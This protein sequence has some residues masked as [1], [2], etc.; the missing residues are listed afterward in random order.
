[1]AK[2]TTIRTDMPMATPISTADDRLTLAQ[3]LSPAFPIGGFAYSQGLEEPMATGHVRTAADVEAWLRDCLRFGTPKMDAIIVA[4]ARR[5]ADAGMLSD[6]ILAYASCAERE[7]ELMEQGRAFSAL[8]AAMSDETVSI[9]PFPVAVGLATRALSL[10]DTEVI[11][12]FLH[13]VAAQMISAATRFLPLGQSE[14][15]AMLARLAPLLTSL[16]T[17]AAAAQLDDIATFTPGADM[18]AMRH[19]TLEVRIFRT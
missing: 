16:A 3:W 17:E 4:Q 6:L 13:G 5:G 1:M 12:L 11:A 2:I 19:E 9:R 15:Q 10:P 8:M 7:L 18:A 14:A